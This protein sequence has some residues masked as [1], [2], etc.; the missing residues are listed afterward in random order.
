[1]TIFDDLYRSIQTRPRPED[2]AQLILEILD[3]D[4]TKQERSILDVAARY[5]FKR[6]TYAYS[7]MAQDF[8]HVHGAE[9]QVRL[10]ALA[11][12]I[13]DPPSADECLDVAIVETFLLRLAQQIQVVPEFIDFMTNRLNREQRA[14]SGIDIKKRRYNKMFRS[15]R[16]IRAKLN[17]MIDNHKKYEVT[18][19]AKSAGAIKITL[20]DLQKDLNTACFVAYLSARMNLRSA[21]TNSVQVRAFDQIAQMLLNRAKRSTPNWWAIS[22]IHPEQDVLIHLS[23]EERGRLLGMWT[24]TLHTLA[25]MLHDLNRVN[26]FDLKNCIVHKGNDSTAWNAV[27]GAWN[28][29]RDHW[30]ALLFASKMEFLLE[31]YCPGKVLRL[32]ASDVVCWQARRPYLDWSNQDEI[33][34]VLHPDTLIWRNL[35]KPWDVFEGLADCPSS[36]V[37]DVVSKYGYIA[38]GWTQPKPNKQAVAFKP[39]PE[40]VHGV[41]VSSPYLARHLKKMGWFSGKNADDA[42]DASLR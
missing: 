42:G 29:A 33:D 8:A 27:A 41:V 30:I 31:Y 34:K 9:H 28:K 24:E 6:Y 26:D 22:L 32:M 16:R 35:P 14:A 3:K 36:L 38:S 2:V 19:I 40:L 23:D 13:P 20:E 21:F 4:L 18:R 1:M 39:T 15:M 5:S 7:S 11:F 25:D 37:E 12:S 10:A 17:R